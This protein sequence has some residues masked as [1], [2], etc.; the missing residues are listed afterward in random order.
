[1][2]FRIL[3]HR[4]TT[5]ALL[6][7]GC[8]CAPLALGQH[9]ALAGAP[10]AEATPP[11]HPLAGRFISMMGTE[12]TSSYAPVYLPYEGEPAAPGVVLTV[13][14]V[15]TAREYPAMVRDGFFVFVPKGSRPGM[16]YR[17]VVHADKPKYEVSP[18]VRVEK[19]ADADVVEVYIY[20]KLFTA[21]HY[22]PELKKPFLWPV[23]SLDDIPVTRDYPMVEGNVPKFAED[24]HHHKSWW[25][26]YGDVA[27]ADCWMEEE[28]SGLQKT[29]E[30]TFGS[31]DAYGWI[32]AKNTWTKADGTP[33]VSEERE[34]RFYAGEEEARLTDM[35][36]TF[37]ADKD[38]VLFKDTKEGGICAVRMRPELS[39]KNGIITN[40]LGDVGEEKVW[41]KPAAWCDYSG[42]IEGHGKRGLTI[43]DNP[44]NLRHPTSWHV[45]KYG[46]MGANPFGYSHFIEMD[47]NKG[48]IPDNGDYTIEPGK[49]LTFNYRVYVHSGDATDAKVADRYADY[50]NP[51]KA[52]WT[53]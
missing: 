3:A 52:A 10:E 6:A 31:G 12:V 30:V 42:P 14:Q 18:V 51:P 16:E 36:V 11:A 19:K 35:R 4:L 9:E 25:A 44:G 40:A 48:L 53:E 20:D 45:R 32:H 17:Y 22:G 13:E 33:V 29:N 49:E 50:V 23:N 46:L 2:K 5:A 27:G 1:M 34:Y 8:C 7:A 38:A 43:M 41:G 28:G 37:K 24:H 15:G 26:S 39:Y 47:Y 21:Y